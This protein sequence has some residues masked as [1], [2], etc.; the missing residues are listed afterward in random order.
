MNVMA[1]PT[2]KDR[3]LLIDVIRGFALFGILLVNVPGMNSLS[4]LDTVDLTFKTIQWDTIIS[5][6]ILSLAEDKFYP[7]FSLLFGL[8]AMTFME[9]AQAKNLNPRKLLVIR[10]AGLLIFGVLHLTFV[11]WGDI[12]LVYAVVGLWLIFF[13]TLSATRLL[14]TALFILSLLMLLH[15]YLAGVEQADDL[16]NSEEIDLIYQTGTFWQITAQRLQDYYY[17]YWGNLFQLEQ[18]DDF[19]FD[20]SYYSQI[21]AIFLLGGWAHKQRLFRDIKANWFII[22]PAG[23]TCLIIGVITHLLA[24][25]DELWEI[26][27]F[28]IYG[29]SLGLGYIFLLICA[30]QTRIGAQLLNPLAVV[31]KTSLTNYIGANLIFSL[32]FYSYGLGLYG[33]ISQGVQLCLILIVFFGLMGL[34]FLWLRYFQFGPLEYLWRKFTYFN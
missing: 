3:I 8:S 19:L 10:L 25:A 14:F 32:L 21:F 12:L 9:N 30:Y 20:L 28:P 34:S 15:L 24:A 18:L 6:L 5:L 22:F 11:W 31:G 7:I 2:T 27:L 13:Y 26:A 33:Q 1:S 23:I 16:T 4:W 17:I 29:L